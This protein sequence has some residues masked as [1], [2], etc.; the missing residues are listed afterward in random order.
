[1]NALH[2]SKNILALIL[3]STGVVMAELG[4]YPSALKQFARTLELDPH[5][6]TALKH[7]QG[8]QKMM[9]ETR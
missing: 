1:M 9:S 5:H 8:A 3:F 2:A 6:K 4:D 7:M